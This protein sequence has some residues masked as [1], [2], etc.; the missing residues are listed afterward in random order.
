MFKVKKMF[1]NEL[2]KKYTQHLVSNDSLLS[3]INQTEDIHTG[4]VRYDK[5]DKELIIPQSEVSSQ[6]SISFDTIKKY[7]IENFST[8]FF[9][10]CE[11]Q[12]NFMKKLLFESIDQV[13]ELTGNKSNIGGK[14]LTADIVL[15]ALEK[16]KIQFDEYGNP[17]MPTILTGSKMAKKIKELETS[18]EY[19]RRFEQIINNK[20]E[21]YYAS[22]CYR[23]LSRID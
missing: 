13:T 4:G 22:I 5:N 16:L 11:N 2:I 15:D 23:K 12:I 19:K 21:K 10:L 17:E 9:E 14:P 8:E 18:G 3:I 20:R 6:M 1:E 7:D